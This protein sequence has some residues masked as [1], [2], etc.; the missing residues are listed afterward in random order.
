MG[1]LEAMEYNAKKYRN[2]KSATG[3]TKI[4]KGMIQIFKKNLGP[5]WDMKLT[6]YKVYY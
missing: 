5:N 3:R 6:H 1:S 4:K 2:I